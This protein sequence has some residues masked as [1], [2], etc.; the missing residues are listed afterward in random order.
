MGL[1]NFG[2][3]GFEQVSHGKKKYVKFSFGTALAYL[4][5]PLFHLILVVLGEPFLL[6]TLFKILF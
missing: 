6:I 1:N 4:I 2:K 5:P 3:K